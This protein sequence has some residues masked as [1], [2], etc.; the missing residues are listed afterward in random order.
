MRDQ[1][2]KSKIQNSLAPS[3]QPLAPSLD[4]L[5]VLVVDD[6]FDTRELLGAVLEEYGVRVTSVA[7]SAEALEALKNFEFDVLLSDIGMPDEDGY[8]L[9]RK[10]RE[11]EAE[12]RG[13]RAIAITAYA[14]EDARTQALSAGFQMH[15]SKPIDPVELVAAVESLSGRTVKF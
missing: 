6:Q 11:L 12:K 7:S 1:N 4:G 3:P 2:P 8:T 9:I 15:L 5:R 14:G 13:I 10:V